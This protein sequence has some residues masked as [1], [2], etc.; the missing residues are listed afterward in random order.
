LNDYTVYSPIYSVPPTTGVLNNSRAMWLNYWRKYLLQDAIS[1][2]QWTM[3]KLWKKDYFTYVLYGIGFCSIVYT[4]KYGWVPQRCGLGGYDLFE[5]P[6]RVIVNNTFVN[7]I[8]RRIGDACVLFQFNPDYTPA[9]DIIDV[10]AAQLAELSLTAYANMQNTKISY[11]LTA[12]DK[13]MA[14][15]MA[16]MTDQVVNGEL[17]VIVKE[18]QMGKWDTFSQNVK[19][20]YIVSDIL[21]DMRKLLNMFN[22]EIGIPNAN[23]EKRERLVTNEVESNNA[24]TKCNPKTRLERF[25]AICEQLNNIAGERIMSVDWNPELTK[26]GESIVPGNGQEPK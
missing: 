23:T 18:S 3:P 21:V 8:D 2:Y 6:N 11:V 13:N 19:Q 10:Y 15:S 24:E 20:N 16:K 9:T 7:N 4:A 5:S 17:A 26:V 25:Q 14:Q 12:T 22:T 1:V